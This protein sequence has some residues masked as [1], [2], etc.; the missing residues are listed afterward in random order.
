MLVS[1]SRS[2]KRFVTFFDEKYSL[3]FILMFRTAYDVRVGFTMR[4]LA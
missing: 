3:R 1:G 2:E 4:L